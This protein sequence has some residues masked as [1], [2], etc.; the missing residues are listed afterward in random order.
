MFVGFLALVE[1]FRYEVLSADLD[2][3]EVFLLNMRENVALAIEK[4]KTD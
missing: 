2:R 4:H 1:G 3:G